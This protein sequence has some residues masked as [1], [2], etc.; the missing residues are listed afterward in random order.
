VPAAALLTYE[1]ARRA[2]DA[3]SNELKRRA[4][5]AVIAVADD[6]GELIALMRMDGAPLAS[7]LIAANKAWTAARER[8]PSVELGRAARQP[9]TGFDIAYY[10]DRRYIG[11]GGGVPIAIGGAIVGAVGVSG[12]PEAV[13]MEVAVLGVAAI[14]AGRGIAR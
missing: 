4:L 5:P 7:I 11:W 13:D 9:E 1:D 2:L 6:H 8:K 12:A 14:L 3:I 10:G